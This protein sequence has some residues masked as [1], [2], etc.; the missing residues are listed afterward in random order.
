[1]F[2]RNASF[3]L[4]TSGIIGLNEHS[5][6]CVSLL[7]TNSDPDTRELTSLCMTNDATALTAT[8][9]FSF[10]FFTLHC[11]SPASSLRCHTFTPPSLALS[12]TEHP[13]ERPTGAISWH[14]NL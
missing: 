3:N 8:V 12:K 9:G 7:S 14:L 5:S 4:L 13:G 10:S 11:L 6:Q 2:L 1:M